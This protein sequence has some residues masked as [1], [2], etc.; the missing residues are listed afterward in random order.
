MAE[1]IARHLGS[2]VMEAS[3]AG[4]AALGEV[5]RMTIDTLVRNGYPAEG[6]ESKQVRIG[7]LELADL[8][9]NMSGRPAV[10]A[11][12]EPSKV[13]DWTVEDPYGADA[14]TYQKIFEDIERRVA[15]L[16]ER[17]RKSAQARDLPTSHGRRRTG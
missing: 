2:D 1:A 8:V 13:E 15:K 11:F 6:L 12:D 3:S 16:A 5:Q 10:V 17:L 14:E 4:L 9:V 7:L